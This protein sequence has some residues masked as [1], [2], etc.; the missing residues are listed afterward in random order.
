MSRPD[1]F[2]PVATVTRSGMVESVHNGAVVVVAADGGVTFS[3]GNPEAEVYGRSSNKPLQAQAMLDL[4]VKLGVE[5]TALA[6]ASHSGA[7]EHLTI[8]KSILVANGLD[9]TALQNTPTLPYDRVLADAVVAAGGQAAPVYQNCSGKHATM[10]ATCVANGW[11]VD[12]YLD[13]EHPVQLAITERV[14]ELADGVAHVGIDGCGAPTHATTLVGLARAF[15]RLASRQGDVWQAMTRHPELVGGP[16]RVVTSLMRA[17]PGLLAKDGADGMFAAGLP[18][19]RAVAVKV[20]DGSARA[21]G[22]VVARALQHAG[23]L[24]GV[25]PARVGEPTL[26]HGHP[27]GST[28]PLF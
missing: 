13:E 10:L 3:V 28:T 2:E 7:K 15:G 6:C 9:L 14:A 19:G 5:Q 23:V 11:P 17:V 16:G 18:D 21:A 27:V 4:G 25:D 26:G 12:T 8:V 24:V 20:G 1:D 22:P